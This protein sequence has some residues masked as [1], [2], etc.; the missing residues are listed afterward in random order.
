MP[1][2]NVRKVHESLGDVEFNRVISTDWRDS[3]AE[4]LWNKTKDNA[5][6]CS[7]GGITS[8]TGIQLKNSFAEKTLVDTGVYMS[9]QCACVT[10]KV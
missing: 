4:I 2:G 7:C 3:L 1:G 8:C 5:E 6:C 9:Q 10:E